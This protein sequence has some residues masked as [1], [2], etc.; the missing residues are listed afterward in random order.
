MPCTDSFRVM[1]LTQR[2]SEKSGGASCKNTTELKFKLS[3]PSTLTVKCSIEPLAWITVGRSHAPIGFAR[4]Q[5]QEVDLSF[6]MPTKGDEPLCYLYLFGA[7]QIADVAIIDRLWE[8][9]RFAVK[10]LDP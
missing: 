3:P 2:N 10:V 6:R 5:F 4:P 8:T 9:Y 1:V 7:S